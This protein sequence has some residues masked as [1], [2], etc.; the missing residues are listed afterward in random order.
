[1]NVLESTTKIRQL[2]YTGSIIG[3]TASIFADD[4][5]AFIKAGATT[6]M[7]KPFNI[8]ILYNNAEL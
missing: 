2:G 6:V 8:E 1:M 3:V 5:V 7:T 4:E